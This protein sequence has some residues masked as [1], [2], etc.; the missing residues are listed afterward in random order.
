MSKKSWNSTGEFEITLRR[1]IS[2]FAAQLS[3]DGRRLEKETG[4]FRISKPN[5]SMPLEG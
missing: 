4:T 5:R 3:L 2:R 1:A